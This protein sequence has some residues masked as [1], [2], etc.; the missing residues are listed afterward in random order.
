MAVISLA[1]VSAL[2]MGSVSAF[3]DLSEAQKLI[4]ERPHLANTSDGQTITYQ[5]TATEAGKQVVEDVATLSING[6]GEK[7]LRDVEVDF[8]TEER[9]LALPPF[10]GWRGNP[11]IIAMLEH[12]AQ[13]IGQATGGGALYFRNRIRDA[14]AS[15]A[16]T[17]KTDR[18]EW[19]GQAIDVTTLAFSPFVGDD[20]I[21]TNPE[22]LDTKF[23]ITLSDDVPGGLLE[24][25]V[26]AD[27]SPELAFS[28]R[29]VIN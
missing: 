19:N 17:I 27:F 6:A 14:M 22:F 29:I 8:L 5:Y 15:E 11:I 4:Y 24:L 26:G 13:S 7:E 3:E 9:R 28:K 16:A 1:V 12:T 21:E 25:Q 18:Q 2:T 10:D 23:V 20:Y